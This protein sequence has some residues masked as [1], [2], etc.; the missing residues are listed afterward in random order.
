V[1]KEGPE[2]INRLQA[3]VSPALAMLAG[4]QLEVFTALAGSQKTATEIAAQL[5][6]DEGRLSRL[7]H[8][9]VLTGLL[10]HEGE[11]FANSPEANRFLVKGKT[12]YLGGAHE[13]IADL[14]HADLQTAKSIR[15]GRPA[16]LHDFDSMDEMA[17][18]AFLRGLQAYAF[19]TGEALAEQF[20]FSRCHSVIDIGGGSGATLLGLLSH[21]ALVRGT[22]FELAKVARAARPLLAGAAGSERIEIEVGD[23]VAAPPKGLHDAAILRAVIQVMSSQDAACAIEHA[24]TCLRP[25]GTIFIT[26]S[27][28]IADDR[29]Q[30]AAGVYLNLTLMNLYPAGAAYTVSTHFDWLRQ[31]GF[32]DPRCATLPNG[33]EVISATRT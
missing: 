13:L 26:G 25:G 8:A 3:G 17:L 5:S 10:V 24:F 23:I 32:D 31:A 1:T 2:I 14:W 6:L 12:A 30:P 4:M 11:R 19:A 15:S 28:I 21:N 29:L 18:S 16:A 20:D 27:G 33:S 22:L 9:L 7:L